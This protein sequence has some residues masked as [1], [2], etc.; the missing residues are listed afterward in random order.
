MTMRSRRLRV[1]FIGVVAA[2][3]A[4]CGGTDRVDTENNNTQVSGEAV[5]TALQQQ[6]AKEGVSGAQVSC[7]KKIIVNVGPR[8][9]CTLGSAAGGTATSAASSSGGGASS[10]SANKTVTFTFKTLGG[11]IDLSSVKGS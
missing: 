3:L 10:T 9:T 6:L 2:A 1:G 5:A 8:V 11:K 4:G 7:A